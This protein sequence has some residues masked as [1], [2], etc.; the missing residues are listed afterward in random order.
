M[1][2]LIE[3]IS[4]AFLCGMKATATFADGTQVQLTPTCSDNGD[5]IFWEA[6]APGVALT[7]KA[8]YRD[9]SALF[10]AE[11]TAD[12]PLAGRALTFAVNP[13]FGEATLASHHDNPWWMY[14][15]WPTA[16]AEI[17]N[18]TQQF[19]VKSGMLH[20]SIVGL[21]G[22]IFRCE[23]D[24]EGLHLN[25]GCDGF[26]CF[27]GPF[28]TIT[29]STDPLLAVENNYL[30]AKEMGAIQVPLRA[31]RE[32][33][34]MFEDFGWCSWNA[35][36]QDVTAD[37]LYDKMDEFKEK[38][39][40]VKWIIIDDG[41]ST[42]KDGKLVDFPA[43]PVKFPAVTLSDGTVADGLTACIRK[44]KEEYG[45]EKVGVWH[46]FNGYWQGIA[47]DSPLV[48]RFGDAL[49][50]T[51]QGM[52]IPSDDPEKAYRFWDAWHGYL[53]ECGVDFVKV[54]NQSSTFNY[55]TGTV[56]TTAGARH[57][58]TAIER[59]INKHF[60]GVVI[61]CM[62]MDMENVLARPYSAVSR[63]SDDFFPDRE[64]GFAKHIQQNLYSAIWHS[65]IHHC[66]YDMWWSGKSAPVQSG[67]LRAISGGTVYTSDQVG[68]TDMAGLLPVCGENGDLCRLDNAAMPTLDCI[69][70]NCEESGK[71]LKAF[72]R[73][74]DALV[75]AVFNISRWDITETFAYD[76]M[77]G[78]PKD[79]EYVAYEYFTKTWSR[80]H[81]ASEETVTLS[82]DGVRCWSLYPVCRD[83]YDETDPDKDAY[84]LLGETER[85]TGIGSREK[86]KVTLAELTL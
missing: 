1:H 50:T 43:D 30:F 77:P 7:I 11:L 32:Y 68:E 61:D 29:V 28:L 58:H 31:E 55:L 39:V 20:Y 76:V 86:K 33:P 38:S 4:T 18:K 2:K 57:A 47:P 46:A 19:L 6:T 60:G 72:N 54:D 75:L 14:C 52:I 41:W 83:A 79:T 67:L 48:E 10:M 73:K 42:Y 3:T 69:Y 59:S 66:D 40:P 8:S 27:C 23:A 13:G 49:M 34:A 82:A 71:L 26:Q 53:A 24:G 80:V 17:K 78:M 74:D 51:V 84:I 63:N 45:I 9:G 81:F 12:K 22:D 35:F 62:G 65:Q 5:N 15:S 70:V 44:I 36:Y 56:S 21:T 37:K 64:N 16:Q 25:S 85:Y